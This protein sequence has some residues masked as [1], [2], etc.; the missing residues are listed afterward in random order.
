MLMTVLLV[1]RRLHLATQGAATAPRCPPAPLQPQRL[2][3][4]LALQQFQQQVRAMGGSVCPR[5][6]MCATMGKQARHEAD[7]STSR[8]H[9][10]APQLDAAAAADVSAAVTTPPASVDSDTPARI[11]KRSHKG[12]VQYL[13]AATLLPADDGQDLADVRLCNGCRVASL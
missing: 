5:D 13:L 12:K 1:Q 7:T 8:W 10:G 2:P 6:S 4:L 3:P 9:A 11:T